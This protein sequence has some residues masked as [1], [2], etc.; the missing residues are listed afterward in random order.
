MGVRR[1]RKKREP[2]RSGIH[3]AAILHM[4]LACAA[5]TYTFLKTGLILTV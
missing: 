5:S 2:K 3:E 4:F 1:E